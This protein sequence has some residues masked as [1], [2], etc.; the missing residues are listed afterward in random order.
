MSLPKSGGKFQAAFFII[1]YIDLQCNNLDL[2]QYWFLQLHELR[3]L[4]STLILSAK[5]AAV[6]QVSQVALSVEQVLKI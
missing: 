2:S 1:S 5:I 4:Q 6:S 3:N